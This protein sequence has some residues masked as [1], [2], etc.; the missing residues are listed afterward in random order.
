[1]ICDDCDYK[2]ELRNVEEELENAKL[3]IERLK[4][5]LDEIEYEINQV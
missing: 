5:I 3:E 4:K 2:I 1:M